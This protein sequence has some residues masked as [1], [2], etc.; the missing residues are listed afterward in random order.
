M[1]IAV[2]IPDADV[3]WT[4]LEKLALVSAV[5]KKG[6]SSWP[7]VSRL[8]RPYINSS[9]NIE[10]FSAKNCALKYD[11]LLEQVILSNVILT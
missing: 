8:I 2:V 4:N 3:E 6:D 1:S 10:L 5:V 11:Y 7:T 9:K